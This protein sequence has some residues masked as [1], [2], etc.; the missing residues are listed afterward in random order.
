M[1]G[2]QI[3]TGDLALRDENHKKT[4]HLPGRAAFTG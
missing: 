3:T 1:T 4:R 2:L